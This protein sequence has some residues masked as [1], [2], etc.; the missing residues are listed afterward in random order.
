MYIP[1]ACRD[2][3]ETCC[4]RSWCYGAFK[5]QH[6][7][8]LRI[9]ENPKRLIGGP[10][11]KGICGNIIMYS[12]CWRPMNK[13]LQT[14]SQR[15]RWQIFSASWAIW[16][17]SQL[18]TS[19]I[20]GQSSHGELAKEWAWLYSNKTLLAGQI[21]PMGHSFPTLSLEGLKALR[22]PALKEQ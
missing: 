2:G 3:K 6:V 20:L 9:L 18:L 11:K 17:L 4:E 15:A 8:F 1:W 10:R 21:W 22:S 13:G 19:T 12:S 16:S 7:H 14:F 5:L